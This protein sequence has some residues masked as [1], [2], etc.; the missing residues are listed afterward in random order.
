M[1][2]IPASLH[3]PSTYK[4]ARYL[5]ALDKLQ[6][7][8]Q[9][10]LTI[11][12]VII[13]LAF[14]LLAPWVALQILEKADLFEYA[15][16]G[17]ILVLV[18]FQ[19]FFPNLFL[20]MWAAKLN[21]QLPQ[22]GLAERIALGEL[23]KHDPIY[24]H[25]PW[26][27]RWLVPK[28]VSGNPLVTLGRV[29]GSLQWY[30]ASPRTHFKQTWRMALSL[31]PFIFIIG[32]NGMMMSRVA[33]L[34]LGFPL[35]VVALTVPA[36]FISMVVYNYVMLE[37]LAKYLRRTWE[38]NQLEVEITPE[39]VD[40]KAKLQLMLNQVQQDLERA[41]ASLFLPIIMPFAMGTFPVIASTIGRGG[42]I[43]LILYAAFFG[44]LAWF[45]QHWL[46]KHGLKTYRKKLQLQLENSNVALLIAA[47]ELDSDG[48]IEHTPWAFRFFHNARQMPKGFADNL[49]MQIWRAGLNLDWFLGHP[50]RLLRPAWITNILLLLVGIGSLVFTIMTPFLMFNRM[51]TQPAGNAPFPT[52]AEM[53]ALG[54]LKWVLLATALALAFPGTLHAA[55]TRIWVEELIRHLRARLAD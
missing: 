12:R 3:A 55:K 1:D 7:N 10:N 2:E 11:C 46:P 40:R 47:G 22:S 17:F 45:G 41:L 51:T 5:A 13:A 20:G 25:T 42:F 16:F 52:I 39:D 6:R 35:V 54:N 4:P 31:L 26:L 30:L 21:E 34:A 18:S 28:N 48:L 44:G 24:G 29:A 8:T 27:L 14:L 38:E 53:F 36:V 15:F 50:R 43:P 33:G 9:C 37:M 19:A 23:E 49:R 32:F